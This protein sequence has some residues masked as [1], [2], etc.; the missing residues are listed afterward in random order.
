[1]K[2]QTDCETLS[3]EQKSFKMSGAL[4]SSGTNV[5]P[6]SFTHVGFSHHCLTALSVFAPELSWPP[7][8]AGTWY[9]NTHRSAAGT[10]MVSEHRAAAAVSFVDFMSVSRRQSTL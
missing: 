7:A 6:V 4:L 9:Q 1:M 2:A 3:F 10:R 8:A 5:L